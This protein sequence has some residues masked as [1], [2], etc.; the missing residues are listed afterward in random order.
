MTPFRLT[1]MLALGLWLWGP[2][3]AAAQGPNDRSRLI[4]IY[5]TDDR[6]I[7]EEDGPP[8][9]AIGRVNRKSGGFCTGLLITPHH[10]LTAAHCLWNRRTNRWFSPGELVFLPGYRMGSFLANQPVRAIRPAP[11]V[12]MDERG[13]PRNLAH[14][15]AV[16]TLRQP[17]F[18]DAALQ[19]I[20]LAD[21]A[22]RQA[23]A[24]GRPLVRAGYSQDRPHVPTSVR[25]TLLGRSGA[26][27]LRHDCDGTWGDSGSP[28]LLE[29]ADG[30]RV[31]GL[32]VAVADRG[33]NSFGIAN[34]IPDSFELPRD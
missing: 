34:V 3:P 32:S 26:L 12:V 8:W 6:K 15:W 25:C 11:G 27:L 22:E 23:V 13:R 19:P 28:I 29:T 7:I 24:A 30:W 20:A 10:V 16:L 18:P 5:G 4:G 33:A 9:S 1:V 17:L 14:D 21:P 2:A 31:L